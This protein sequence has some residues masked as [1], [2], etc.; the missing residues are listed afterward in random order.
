MLLKLLLVLVDCYVDWLVIND[1][2]VVYY[3]IWDYTCW[4]RRIKTKNQFAGSGIVK[5]RRWLWV[6][7]DYKSLQY[8]VA[9]SERRRNNQLNTH[10]KRVRRGCRDATWSPWCRH[11][12]RG[13]CRLS[14]L[15]RAV[16]KCL[17]WSFAWVLLHRWLPV[18]IWIGRVW[19]HL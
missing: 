5:H 18:G 10:N 12:V 8:S 3:L 16:P 9:S 11:G 19:R 14:C 6:W 7:K 4:W 15:C 1:T 2:C 13:R 17:W